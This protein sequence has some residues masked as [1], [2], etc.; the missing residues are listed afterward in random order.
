MLSFAMGV[1]SERSS[2]LPCRQILLFVCFVG[3]GF[4]A[5]GEKSPRRLHHTVSGGPLPTALSVALDS[6]TSPLTMN[7]TRR[8]SR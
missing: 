8:F 5:T 6:T 1:L 4:I 7:K 2:P 3:A